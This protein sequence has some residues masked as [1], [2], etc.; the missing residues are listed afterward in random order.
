MA[1]EAPTN[2]WTWAEQK[3]ADAVA[4]SSRFWEIVNV[5]NSVD[6]E[7]FI[8]G[9][10]QVDPEDGE[11]LKKAELEELR[12]YAQVYSSIENAYTKVL[13]K[14]KKYESSGSAILF[15]E[16]LVTES[17]QNSS[18]APASTHRWWKNRTGDV[19]DQ[20]PTYLV[21][22]GG[23][24]ILSM[25]VTDGP[26]FI[27]RNRWDQQGLWQAIEWTINWGSI[28]NGASS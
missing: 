27:K 9:D 26:G 7:K 23:P 20:L 13:G 2:C 24:F 12:Y 18:D 15:M 6:A 10:Q 19:I 5:T 25:S 1:I 21:D 3:I 17:E 8:F 28:G 4:N 22:N 11:T 14:T 16:R